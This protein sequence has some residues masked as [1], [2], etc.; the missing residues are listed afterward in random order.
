MKN[1]DIKSSQKGQKIAQDA[2]RAIRDH[3]KGRWEG[4]YSHLKDFIAHNPYSKEFLEDIAHRDNYT[5]SKK[6]SKEQDMERFINE[7]KSHIQ[8]RRLRKW[9]TYSLSAAAALIV[10][11][12]QIYYASGPKVSLIAEKDNDTSEEIILRP[13][14]IAADGNKIEL[15][16]ITNN[17]SIYVVQGEKTE[18]ADIIKYQTIV[19]PCGYTFKVILA[20]SSEVM[21]NANSKLRYPETFTGEK[22]EVTLEGEGYFNV[23]KSDK[24]FVV[25]TKNAVIEVYGTHFNI[26][27]YSST[28]I[29]TTLISGQVGVSVKGKSEIAE[30]MLTPNHML[31]MNAEGES[32]I[33]KVDPV[34]HTSWMKGDISVVDEPLLELLNRISRWYGVEF[35]IDKK[36]EGVRIS[37]T[38]SNTMKLDQVLQ[39]IIIITEIRIVKQKE[40]KYV[41]L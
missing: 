32:M 9:V 16:E 39:S 35:T 30:I 36:I 15:K 19:V 34:Q 28:R 6:Y 24:P 31:E 22:R 10:L 21:L 1:I 40:G 26:N 11:S 8:K 41:I 2:I 25:T 13:T 3:K 4:E 33:V 18:Q 17:Q 12:L 37:A 14:L 7:L 38:F 29:R 5:T 20:D 23:R 27:A